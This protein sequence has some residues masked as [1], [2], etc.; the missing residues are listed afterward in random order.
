MNEVLPEFDLETA[1]ELFGAELVEEIEEKIKRCVKREQRYDVSIIDKT[2]NFTTITFV[3]SSWAYL[4]EVD[5]K[6]KA[7]SSKNF[8]GAFDCRKIFEIM[9][10][11]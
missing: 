9:D 1:E 3:T 10:T 6:G 5:H 2:Q 4:Y 8:I 7:I 11:L